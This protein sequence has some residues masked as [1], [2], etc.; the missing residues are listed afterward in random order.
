MKRKAK[1]HMNWISTIGYCLYI[2]ALTIY[3]RIHT[4]VD[5]KVREE[6]FRKYPRRIGPILLLGSTLMTVGA[7]IDSGWFGI[8]FFPGT[9]LLF[10][11]FKLCLNKIFEK[12][13]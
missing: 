5:G 3:F 11:L 7:V 9:L 12:H 6:Y 8:C 4:E 2:F 1:Q 10:Y 13:T